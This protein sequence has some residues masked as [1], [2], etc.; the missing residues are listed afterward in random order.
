MIDG[1]CANHVSLNP[2]QQTCHICGATPS[3][4]NNLDF[5]LTKPCHSEYYH[6][7]LSTLQCRIFF[8]E[9]IL[10]IAYRLPFKKW[11][12]RGKDHQATVE[13]EKR[14]IQKA[15]KDKTGKS[16]LLNDLLSQISK[17]NFQDCF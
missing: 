1:N 3:E 14:R 2:S 10:H 6:L 16:V 7:G 9:N 13:A 8:L 17:L 15:F 4:M 12:A 11:Q 5:I